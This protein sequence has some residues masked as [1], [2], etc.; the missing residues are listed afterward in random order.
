MFCTYS[1][2]HTGIN[3]AIPVG[4][5]MGQFFEHLGFEVAREWYIVGE[6][7]GR[8]D[9]STMGKLGD[10]RGRPNEQDLAGVESDVSELVSSILAA[11]K[12]EV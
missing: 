2:P 12:L 10:I 3:E 1:G 9:H 8:E 5:Y 11:P 6:F 4:K 7:H